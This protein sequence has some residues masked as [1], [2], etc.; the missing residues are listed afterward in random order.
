MS[1]E[2]VSRTDLITGGILVIVGFALAIGWEAWKDARETA[3]RDK[4][5]NDVIA[6]DLAINKTHLEF[7]LK[8]LNQELEVL[9]KGLSVVQPLPVLQDSFWDIVKLNPP[10]DLLT[11]GKLEKLNKL[12]AVTSV[13][14]DQV[15]SR[16]TY[17]LQN[18]AMSNFSDRMRMYDQLLVEQLGI[19]QRQI[20]EYGG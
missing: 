17:R 3:Q 11:S 20:D 4:A 8:L 15:K 1:S 18:G 19:L 12:M 9:P 7:S 16:E 10:T 2:L 6:S 14:N 13:I 5:L